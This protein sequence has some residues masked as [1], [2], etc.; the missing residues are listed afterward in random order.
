MSHWNG[1]QTNVSEIQVV[2]NWNYPLNEKW[3]FKCQLT[4]GIYWSFV[5]GTQRIKHLHVKNL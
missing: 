4:H 2:I 3:S 1:S 5:C